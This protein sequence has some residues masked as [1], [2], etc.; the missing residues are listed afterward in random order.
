MSFEEFN[1]ST[2]ILNG[3][4]DINFTEPTPVQTECIPRI[5]EG[6]DI[7]A[8]AQTGTGKTAAFVIPILSKLGEN[9]GK[10]VKALILTPTRELAHQVDEQIMA[11]GYYTGITSATVYGG[12]APTDWNRQEKALYEEGVNIIVATPGRLID[13]ITIREVDFSKLDYFVLDEADR[14]LDMGFLPDVRTI[15]SRLPRKRQNLLFSATIPVDIEKFARAITHKPERVNIATFQVASGIDQVAYKVHWKDKEKLLLYLLDKKEFTSSIIFLSTKKGTDRL[16]NKLSGKGLKVGCMHGDR[17]QKEREDALRNFKSGKYDILVA[18]DV[19]SRGIDIDNISHIINYDMPKNVDDYIHRI[20]RTAR[21]EAEG[22][23]VTFV[24]KRDNKTLNDIQ[25]VVGDDLR[26][27]SL[28]DELRNRKNGKNS[29]NG[30]K[31]PVKGNPKKNKKK[32]SS[33]SGTA[34]K[35]KGKN[36]SSSGSSGNKSDHKNKKSN[37]TKPAKKQKRVNKDSGKNH[38]NNK[39]SARK[40]SNR[41]KKKSPVNSSNNPRPKKKNSSSSRSRKNNNNKPSTNGQ[42]QSKRKNKRY[43]NKKGK[44]FQKESQKS[45]RERQRQSL[46]DA[47]ATKR[48][49]MS[50]KVTPGPNSKKKKGVI[51]LIKKIFNKDS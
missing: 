2:N 31:K 42:T 32:G 50:N 22:N 5:L 45:F 51:G 40:T 3:L 19:L 4:R 35:Q 27:L 46:R 41:K 9:P 16:A 1:L 26:V 28:P 11:L 21:A 14:M 30:K 12:G 47:H 8:S 37:R 24:S 18:T 44:P 39:S 43:K 48:A 6:N 13:H 33:S 29:K 15:E 25:K 7:I 36:N 23:A 20:G 49:L 34:K 10:G 17:S 38:Q